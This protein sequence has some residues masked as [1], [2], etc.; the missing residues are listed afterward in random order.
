VGGTPTVVRELSWRLAEHAHVEVASLKSGGVVVEQ[1]RERRINV[2]QF[3]AMRPAELPAVVLSLR[4]FIERRG[5]DVVLSF[6][7][8]ANLVASVAGGPRLLQ[9]IQ[10]S[11]PKPRWHWWMQSLAQRS[12]EQ[13]VVPSP[14]VAQLA[15]EW[16]GVP[17]EKL[18]IIPNALDPAEYRE[19][20][21][22]RLP[23]RGDEF[24]VGFVGRLDPVKRIPDLVN[25]MTHLSERF[26]LSIFGEGAE[27]SRLERQI[28]SAGLSARVHLRGRVTR[29]HTAL[30]QIDAMV[31]PS[32]AE[33][34]GLVLIE[35]MAAGVP[36]VATDVPGVR[37]VVAHEETGLLVP[38]ESPAE[39]AQAIRRVGSDRALRDR[40]TRNAYDRV[41]AEYG[42]GRVLPMYRELLGC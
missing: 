33:G 40:L 12:A 21:L 6:L 18:V 41:C 2:K 3:D 4:R 39:L 29:P 30:A 31:L 20:A 17:A 15:Q 28:A 35:A 13:V 16:S 11:Q 34:F 8:H 5:F 32:I 19:P 9:S 42:W 38:A 24:R 36:I 1:L 27:R 7:A 23:L 26:E 14:S 25:A 37:D 10:T 22:T